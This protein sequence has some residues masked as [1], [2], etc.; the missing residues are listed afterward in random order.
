LS[1]VAPKTER[2]RRIL[3]RAAPLVV[4]ASL[5]FAVGAAVAG[6]PD[7]PEAQRF[8]AAWERGDIDAMHDEL[9]PEAQSEFPPEEFQRI[10]AD[11][12]E[13]ATV[14]SLSTG[15]VSERD[16]AAVAQ[17]DFDTYA[18]GKLGGEL[19]LPISDDEIAWTPN[20]V[21]PGLGPDERLSRRTRA[22]ARA[23]ILA[24][25]RSPLA[26]GPAAA[27]TVGTAA[28]AVAG[29][30][31]TPTRAQ[32]KQLALRGFPPGSLTGTSGLELAWNDRLS[33][34]PGGQLVAATAAQETEIGGGR[35]LATS[36]PVPGEAVRTTIDPVLQESAVS[37]LGGLFGGVAVLD[38]KQG[39]VLALSGIAYSS[40][41]PPGSTFKVITTTGA[42]DAGIVSLSDEFPVETSN[43]LIGREI[44]NSH[45]SACGGTFAQS[46]AN[47]CNTVFAPL[48]AELGGPELVETA[49]LFG[50]NQTPQIFDPQASAAVDPPPSTIPADLSESVETGESAIGQGQVL[51]TPLEMATVSQ[52]I[53][54]AGV[55]LP[56]AIARAEELQPAGEPVEVTSKATAATVR[57]LMIGVVNGGTGVA[58]A[59]PGIEVA[60]KTGTAEL[61]PTALAA[62]DELGPGEEAPQEL[63]AWFTAFAPA[64]DP[65]L[66]VAVLVVDSAGD[67]GEIAAPIARQ[68]LATGLGVE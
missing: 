67:G 14:A 28:V 38:A 11:A 51:A 5:A 18:F 50:F 35:L 58:A 41:Q 57:D 13:T 47:S 32:A 12:A 16:G 56:T 31:S 61:G 39:D 37:A 63:D 60:G 64:N 59:L 36:E 23:P 66:A 48:G 52:T 42:L 33:G 26:E 55:R 43:S 21:Y 30:V 68:V 53:A 9:T 54:N 2:R 29:S 6:G 24:A 25:D 20:L 65:K 27:R 62:G 40:P 17:V 8:L 15:E 49:E 4:L 7:A 46:F 10:Y 22:P 19:S 1:S 44:A 34:Q 3:T 45:D